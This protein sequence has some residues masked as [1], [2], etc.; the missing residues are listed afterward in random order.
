VQVRRVRFC[1]VRKERGRTASHGFSDQGPPIKS[2]IPPSQFTLPIILRTIIK[3][4]SNIILIIIRRVSLLGWPRRGSFGALRSTPPLRST[5]ATGTS[6]ACRSILLGRA[7]LRHTLG[8]LTVA[9]YGQ[10]SQAC[11]AGHWRLLVGML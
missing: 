7:E 11:L 10:S 4:I 1:V 8:L 5:L 9:V 6:R 3:Y 2:L